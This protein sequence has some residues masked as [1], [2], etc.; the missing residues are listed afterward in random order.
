MEDLLCGSLAKETTPEVVGAIFQLCWAIGK[1]GMAAFLMVISQIQMVQ[2]WRLVW[3][4]RTIYRHCSW[5]PRK[6]WLGQAGSPSGPI[7]LPLLLSNSILRAYSSSRSVAAFGIKARDSSGSAQLWHFGRVVA[8]SAFFIEA[9]ALRIACRVAIESNFG[10]VIL[11]S[12]CKW[13]VDC[14]NSSSTICLWEIY[15]IVED[16]KAWASLRSWSF[17]WY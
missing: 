8:S 12:D 14:L 15:A 1:Q 5:T 3:L 16:V 10:E 6:F 9:W 11:E 4:I 7:F 13:L 2:S 17:V